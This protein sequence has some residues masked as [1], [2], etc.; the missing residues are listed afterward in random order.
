MANRGRMKFWLKGAVVAFLACPT[1]S[2]QLSAIPNYRSM[3]SAKQKMLVNCTLC[4][5]SDS[6]DLNRYGRDFMK[7]GRDF[8]AFRIL[9]SSDSDK[10]G[11]TTSE[12][13]KFKSNPGDPASTPKRPGPWLKK[14]KSTFP[15]KKFLAPLFSGK[16][17][18]YV[19]EEA[20]PEKTVAEIEK[21]LER[22][23]RDEEKYATLFWI[24]KKDRQA[25]VATYLVLPSGEDEINVFLTVVDEDKIL[26]VVRIKAETRA[27]GSSSFLKQ[28]SNKGVDE[29]G[30]VKPLKKLEKKSLE[31]IDSIRTTAF[32]LQKLF[33]R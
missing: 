12:E 3:I 18:Y 22:K 21:A 19:Q 10:D 7:E 31:L 5:Q 2:V 16:V 27:L 33:P 15:P 8:K 9:E 23:L 30:Q 28:F 11:F 14:A 32:I 26:K 4:H 13:W 29:L 25:G 6:W 24:L 20:L 17:T 1:H